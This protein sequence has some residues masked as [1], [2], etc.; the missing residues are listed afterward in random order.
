MSMFV[1]PE[2]KLFFAIAPMEKIDLLWNISKTLT[3]TMIRSI[4]VG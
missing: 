3:D 1:K 4:E 2:V